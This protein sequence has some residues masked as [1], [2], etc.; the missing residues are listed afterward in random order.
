M[1]KKIYMKARMAYINKPKDYWETKNPILEAG[2]MGFVSDVNENEWC[3]VGDGV[4]PWVDLPWKKGPKGEAGEKGDKGECAEADMAYNPE[5]ENAQSGKAVA[6]AVGN[7]MDKFAEASINNEDGFT[8]L[9]TP[10][11]LTITSEQRIDLN[12]R[13]IFLGSDNV[14]MLGFTLKNVG[15]PTSLDEAANKHYVDNA[16]G[17]INSILKTLV[18]VE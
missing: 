13:A 6:E 14:S 12:A 17:D 3:K 11:V 5:S 8:N 4:T 18:E 1:S 2:E 7:K 10:N 9:T 15:Y 16:I